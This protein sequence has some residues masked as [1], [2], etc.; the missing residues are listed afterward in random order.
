MANGLQTTFN[1]ALLKRQ[2]G[3]LPDAIRSFAMLFAAV[4]LAHIWNQQYLLATISS[5]LTSVYALAMVWHQKHPVTS[6]K[7]ANIMALILVSVLSLYCL[8]QMLY[9]GDIQQ[10]T[11][12]ILSLIAASILLVNPTQ[13]SAVT[14]T[15]LVVWL[16]CLLFLPNLIIAD[17]KHHMALAVI[18][19]IAA[20][21]IFIHRY[22]LIQRFSAESHQK[23]LMEKTLKETNRQLRQNAMHDTLTGVANRRH[24]EDYLVMAWKRAKIGSQPITLMLCDI[25]HLSKYNEEA[26]HE[27]GDIALIRVTEVIKR[28]IR[29]PQD[30]LARFSGEAFIIMFQN[31][32]DLTARKVAARLCQQ[33][34]DEHIEYSGDSFITVSIG[35]ATVIPDDNNNPRSAIQEA[36][37]ALYNAKANGRNGF[38]LA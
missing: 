14:A 2:K 32:D 1:N 15:T 30:M 26:G 33:V 38:A 28:T 11:Y 34:Q 23:Q 16:T 5:I 10:S 22:R 25:D 27:A 6:L 3:M 7:M 18:V 9:L 12:L 29:L 37:Y 35:V 24:F 20:A 31:M 36:D 8:F 13:F 17:L 19:T 21:T 4:T